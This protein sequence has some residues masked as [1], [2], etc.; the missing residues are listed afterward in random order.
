MF[1]VG[2]QCTE[3]HL[4]VDMQQAEHLF[5]NSKISEQAP[6]KTLEIV[7]TVFA[8]GVAF[9]ALFFLTADRPSLHIS[10][11]SSLMASTIVQLLE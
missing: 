11:F 10:S 1:T 7:I 5:V 9:L 2:D 8:N 6:V 3:A 4:P